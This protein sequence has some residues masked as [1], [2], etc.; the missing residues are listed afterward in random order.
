MSVGIFTGLLQYFPRMGLFCPK[1]GKEKKLS[2]SVS[3]YLKNWKPKKKNSIPR[4]GG[5]GKGPAI[6]KITVFAASLSQTINFQLHTIQNEY[7]NNTFLNNV[8]TK[9]WSYIF[10]WT[11]FVSRHLINVAVTIVLTFKVIF[12][13]IE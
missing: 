11:P 13:L 7:L 4:G 2:K 6:K 5:E 1:I 10:Q 12:A 3:S 8:N 9:C